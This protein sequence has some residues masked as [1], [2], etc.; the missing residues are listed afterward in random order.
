[1]HINI[2]KSDPYRQ[3]IYSASHLPDVLHNKSVLPNA[4]HG[5]YT[6]SPSIVCPK[7]AEGILNSPLHHSVGA[8]DPATAALVAFVNGQP[9]SNADLA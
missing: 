9:G 7:N 3:Y 1:M 2:Y 6:P 5:L 8:V 4:L